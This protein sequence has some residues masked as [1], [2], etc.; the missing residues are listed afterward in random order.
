MLG[1]R[2]T[3]EAY[4][5][6]QNV[7]QKKSED[8]SRIPEACSPLPAGLDIESCLREKDAKFL[9]RNTE[10]DFFFLLSEIF[11]PVQ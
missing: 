1:S 4:P 5:P 11:K 2:S 10:T 6:V 9:T 3:C 8:I 7:L